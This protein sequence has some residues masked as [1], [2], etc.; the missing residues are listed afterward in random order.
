MIIDMHTHIF[1]DAIADRAV[2]RLRAG[3]HTR[4]FLDGRGAS[5]R[6]SALQAGIDLSVVLPVATSAHQVEHINLRAVKIR[7]TEAETRVTSFGAAH[8]EDPDWK[9]H[10]DQAAAA[11]LQ[12]IKIHPPYQEVDA[13]DPRYLRILNRAGELGLLVVT[14]AGLDVGLPGAEQSTPEKLRRALRAVGPVRLICAHMGGWGCWERVCDALCDTSARID[15]SFSLGPMTPA[16]DGYPWTEKTLARLDPE[17][18]CAMIR[19]FGADRVLFGTDSPWSDQAG[20]VQAFRRLPLTEE[21]KTL[22]LGENARLLLGKH[23]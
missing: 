3:S 4:A 17:T 20:E 23:G 11:G 8:P 6:E 2:S 13:D 1:P 22:I 15:T 16:G 9:K 7:E 12:G 18:F 21:E 19:A 10:L 5:L 14:H